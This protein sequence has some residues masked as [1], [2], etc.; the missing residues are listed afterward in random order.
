[1]NRNQVKWEHSRSEGTLCEARVHSAQSE[2][3]DAQWWRRRG[4]A[5]WSAT[6][7][8]SGFTHFKYKYEDNQSSRP[9]PLLLPAPSA[10]WN[11]FPSLHSRGSETEGHL[12][13]HSF[14]LSVSMRPSRQLVWRSQSLGTNAA[15]WGRAHTFT[16]LSHCWHSSDMLT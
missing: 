12:L 14:L 3:L 16:A 4:A 6:C 5:G 7:L 2:R 1:M 15:L 11:I 13:A 10:S 8:F 9:P